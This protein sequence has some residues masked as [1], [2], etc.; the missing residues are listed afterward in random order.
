MNLG[1]VL[2]PSA[3]VLDVAAASRKAVFDR[4]AALLTDAAG[5]DAAGIAAALV[6]RE[7]Q[8]T[9]GFGSGTAIPHGRLQGMSGIRGAVLRLQQPIDWGGVDGIPVDLVFVLVGPDGAG[10]EQLKALAR[11]SRAFRDQALLEKMR[12]ANDPGALWALLTGEERR[13]A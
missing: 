11:V 9:T 3:V 7:R 13:A 1:A 6:D 10:A 5:A 12:G 4:A 8:G 2:E